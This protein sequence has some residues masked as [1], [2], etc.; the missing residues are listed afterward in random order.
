MTDT[1]PYQDLHAT[2]T[3]ELE[4]RGM[5]LVDLFEIQAWRFGGNHDR[6]QGRWQRA[7]RNGHMN[8]WHAD[9]ALV[10]VGLTFHDLLHARP[11]PTERNRD[12]V[13]AAA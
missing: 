6:Y 12:R 5:R 13:E 2:I 4:R 3:R 1:I 7:K 8:V 10:A 11:A 9:E